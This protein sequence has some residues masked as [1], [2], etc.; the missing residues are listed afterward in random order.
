MALNIT[1]AFGCTDRTPAFCEEQQ[2]DVRAGVRREEATGAGA[3]LAFCRGTW[4]Q[5]CA[6]FFLV[7][8]WFRLFVLYCSVLFCPVLF[9]F[10][11]LEFL[12]SVF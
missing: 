10:V 3:P 5:W 9:C 7:L 8:V 4:L 1:E 11:F 2:K 6:P 12:G